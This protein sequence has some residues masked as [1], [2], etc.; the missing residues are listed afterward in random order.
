V[1]ILHAAS[2]V[3][4]SS[5]SRL[6]PA[7]TGLRQRKNSSKVPEQPARECRTPQRCREFIMAHASCARLP[8][9]RGALW[10]HLLIHGTI[11]RW[12]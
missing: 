4:D 3:C 7:A 6:T 9:Q 1:Q 2:S 10:N 12:N 5:L 11:L 8:E